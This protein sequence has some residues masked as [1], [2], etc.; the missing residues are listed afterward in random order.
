[1]KTLT[2]KVNLIPVLMKLILVAMIIIKVQLKIKSQRLIGKNCGEK[3]TTEYQKVE[4]LKSGR[5]SGNASLNG[6]NI[7]IGHQKNS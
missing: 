4:M 1:M 2:N 6:K 3:N 7:Q 5:E